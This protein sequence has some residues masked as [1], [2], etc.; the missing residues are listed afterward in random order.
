MLFTLVENGNRML[1]E[2]DNVVLVKAR[3]IAER[4]Q[5]FI[6][7]SGEAR[8]IEFRIGKVVTLP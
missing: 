2:T 6:V 7:K 4:P 5:G 8:E 3:L 1:F